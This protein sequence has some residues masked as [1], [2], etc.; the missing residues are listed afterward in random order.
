VQVKD[1]MQRVVTTIA[2]D[3]SLALAKQLMLWN[4]VRHL[5]VLRPADGRATGIISERDILRAHER[6]PGESVMGRPVRDFM[7]SPPEHVHPNADV[8]D[9]AADLST[10]QIGCLLVLD[11]GELVGVVGVSDVLAIVA[12]YPTE[13]LKPGV[14]PN[15]ETVHSIMSA[16]PLVAHADDMLL[17]AVA[18]MT[19]AGVRHLCVVDGDGRALGIVSDRDV[20]ATIGDP[21]RALG[22]KPPSAQLAQLRIGQVMTPNPRTVHEREPI[23]TALD[24]LLTERFGAL[25][26]I[27]DHERVRGMLSYLDVLEHFAKRAG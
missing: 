21:R 3:E 23:T 18:Q 20:R 2:E 13:R 6:E 16:N 19:A 25:P 10:K 9:A 17:A 5:P 26:V 27:D 14:E 7:Q 11:A 1:V 24:A 12:R 22:T 8:A 15:A 4:E